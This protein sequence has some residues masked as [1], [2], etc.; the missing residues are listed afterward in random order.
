M[1]MDA[2]AWITAI[3]VAV[4]VSV[5][6]PSPKSDPPQDTKQVQEVKK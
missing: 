1:K 4:W 3:Y 2:I 6:M 5:Y